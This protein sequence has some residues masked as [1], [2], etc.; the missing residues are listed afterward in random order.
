MILSVIPKIEK[1]RQTN[2][3][4]SKEPEE[5]VIGKANEKMD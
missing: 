4:L 2:F 1:I 3:L 5:M